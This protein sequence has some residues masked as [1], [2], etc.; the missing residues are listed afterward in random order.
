MKEIK[1]TTRSLT[2]AR[3]GEFELRY[4]TY[5]VEHEYTTHDIEIVKWD[6]MSNDDKEYCYTI[7]SFGKEGNLVECGNRL[8]KA[9]RTSSFAAEATTNLET[10]ADIGRLILET[11]PTKINL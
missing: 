1:T 4:K 7:A 9:I 11:E 6:K 8:L 10:L 3:I 2:I 5:I